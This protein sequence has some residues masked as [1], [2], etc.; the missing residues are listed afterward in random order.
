MC[1]KVLKREL[2]PIIK[3]LVLFQIDLIEKKDIGTHC[4]DEIV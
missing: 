4:F 2:V 3:D 1:E